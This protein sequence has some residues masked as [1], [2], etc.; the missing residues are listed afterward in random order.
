MNKIDITE[1]LFEAI[2]VI[3]EQRIR[4]LQYS[5]CYLME[6]IEQTNILG[7]YRVRYQGHSYKATSLG[8][9]YSPGDMVWVLAPRN[10][11]DDELTIA[12]IV[13]SYYR[14]SQ[15]HAV[16]KGKLVSC[17]GLDEDTSY[18]KFTFEKDGVN[19][20]LLDAGHVITQEQINTSWLNKEV[21]Y[22][23]I[24]GVRYIDRPVLSVNN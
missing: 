13:N 1:N 8:Y 6:V 3:M 16:F 9:P 7:V 17:A 18:I 14:P 10:T 12:G 24:D 5:Q 11:L 20:Y 2:D 19:G 15:H 22:F 4:K 21:F 23:E